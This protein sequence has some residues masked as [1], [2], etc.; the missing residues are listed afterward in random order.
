M[1]SIKNL[2]KLRE[3]TGISFNLCKKALEEADND[4]EKA[5]KILKKT[6]EKF[7][8]KKSSNQ[9][10]IG[11]IFSYLHHNRKVGSMVELLCETDFVANNNNFIRLGNDLAMQIT[12][13]NPNNIEEF[14][15]QPFIKDQSKTIDDVIKE[16]VLKLGENIKIGKFIRLAI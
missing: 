10:K 3:E 9:T 7:F 11:A 6:G 4:I 13:M 16:N 1:Y 15:K 5:R 12:S 14:L 2:K 8:E